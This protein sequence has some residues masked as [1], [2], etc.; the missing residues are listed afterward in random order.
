MTA[1]PATVSHSFKRMELI[2]LVVGCFNT[3]Q[4]KM[5]GSF[6]F[7]SGSSVRMDSEMERTVKQDGDT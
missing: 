5:L 7:E 1:V 6:T 4:L 3:Y 2:G